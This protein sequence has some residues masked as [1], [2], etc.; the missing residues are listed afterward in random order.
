M[1]H[2][3]LVCCLLGSTL[4]N[5]A[6]NIPTPSQYFGFSIGDDYMLATFTQTEAYFKQLAAT[7]SPS[8][9]TRKSPTTQSTMGTSIFLP[10]LI[11]LASG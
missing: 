5:I 3:L 2:L 11:T 6:Q 7:R 9:T 1:K 10:S 4:S 8:P